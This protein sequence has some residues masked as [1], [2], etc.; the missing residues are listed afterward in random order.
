LNSNK[1][2][3]RLE[4]INNQIRNIIGDAFIKRIPSSIYGFL[5]ISKV[6]VSPD[7]RKADIYYT[8]FNPEKEKD[9][10]NI[11]INKKRKYFRK[12]LSSEMTTKNTPELFFFYDDSLDYE[13]ELNKIF[14][15]IKNK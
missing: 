4:R 7:L 13:D 11:A 8:V 10:I 2:Y 14:K 9:E 12:I 5:T 1:P 6:N 3:S 15:K